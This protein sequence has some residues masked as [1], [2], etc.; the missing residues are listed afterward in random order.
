MSETATHHVETWIDTGGWIGWQC[1]TC[2]HRAAG[3]T[4]FDEAHAVAD[5]HELENQEAGQ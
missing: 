5:Q 4:S 3:Y 1:R 2:G